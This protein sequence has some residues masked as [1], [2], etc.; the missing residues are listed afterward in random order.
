MR[1]QILLSVLLAGCAGSS[2]SPSAPSGGAAAA[3]GAPQGPALVYK[4]SH[5]EEGS[6]LVGEYTSSWNGFRTSSYWIEGPSGLI[7]IDTQFLLSAAEEFVNTAERVT[8]KKA[9]L[10]VVLHPN[11]DKFNGTGVLQKRGIRVVTSDQ[12]LAKIP[13]VHKLRLGWFYKKF[14]PDYPK[15]VS[16]PESFGAKTT[17][18]EAA[19]LKLKLHVM[20]AGCSEAHV[21][22]QVKDLV[23]VGDLVTR[24]FHS[25]LELGL[26]DE[27]LK[28]LDEIREL[29]PTLVHTGRGGTVEPEHLDWQENYLRTVIWEVG[30]YNPIAGRAPS[31]AQEKKITDAIK[32]KFPGLD[33]PAFIRVAPLWQRLGTHRR[34]FTR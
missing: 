13:A 1:K 32:A 27:W 10:A 2:P 30:K 7:L 9:V 16:L 15:D 26:L 22:A 29:E 21:V 4:V 19:G 3:K 23:F 6:G 28:R 5:D 31:V 25:W 18:L 12:V 34:N 8:G 14:A 11:P 24:G 17:E 20:G 33:Y